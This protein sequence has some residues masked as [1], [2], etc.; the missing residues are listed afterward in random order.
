M[1]NERVQKLRQKQNEGMKELQ[2]EKENFIKYKEEEMKKLEEYREEEVKKMKR[3]KKIAERNQKATANMPNRKEREEIENLKASLTKNNEEFK[4]KEKKFKY[5]I[6]RQKKTIDEMTEKI[7]GLEDEVKFYE[8]LRLKDAKNKPAGKEE[9]NE[10]VQEDQFKKNKKQGEMFLPNK[11]ERNFIWS[12]K[13][14][15]PKKG[16]NMKDGKGDIFDYSEEIVEE[17]EES[18]GDSEEEIDTAYNDIKVGGGRNKGASF[19]LNI[20][21]TQYHYSANKYYTQYLALKGI[22]AKF[23]RC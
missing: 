8:Q 18:F 21:P 5:T 2:K 15:G 16:K 12:K 10:W 22:F 4:T 3:D 7:K 1:E 17:E 11:D 6:D 9:E 23:G 20:D 19:K 14:K 13:S